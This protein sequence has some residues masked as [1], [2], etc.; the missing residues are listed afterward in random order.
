MAAPTVRQNEE[1]RP[2]EGPPEYF[3]VVLGLEH[4]LTRRLPAQGALAIGRGE[5]A[6]VRIVDALASRAH[7][8]LHLGEAMEIEDLGSAN[9]TRLRD[10]P[11]S[12]HQRVPLAPGDA[13]SIGTTLLVVQRQKP[14]FEPR[15]IWSHGHFES[16]LIEVCAEA[17]TAK[18]SFALVR[19]HARGA[20]V[21]EIV[22]S[23]LRPGDLLAAYAPDEYEVLLVDTNRETSNALE[24]EMLARLQRDGAAARAGLAFFPGDGSSPQALVSR[25]CERLR[26]AGPPAVSGGP[27][28]ENAAMRQLYSVAEK[29]ARGTI[30]VLIVGE[31]GA[32]KEILAQ[33]V[34]RLSPRSQRPFIAFNCAALSDSLLES[35]LF[36][37]EK[38][39]FTGATQAKA[40]LLEAAH[41]GTLF[42]DEIGEMSLG[43][44]AKVLRAIESKQVLRVGATKAR[45]VDVRFVAATNRD[46]EEEIA[47]K[48]FREDL[49]FRLNGMT[50]EIP[51]LRDRVDEI[52][53]LARLFLERVAQQMGQ[54]PPPLGRD[55]VAHLQ[56][57]AWPGNIRELRNVM[58]RALLLSSGAAI[59]PEHLPLEKMKRS[60]RVSVPPPSK[61]E[62]LPASAPS[63]PTG[64]VEPAAA[65]TLG[66]L[67]RQAILD[68][69]VRCAGNQSRAA[70]LLGIPR[71][72]FCK[73]LAEYNIPRP[74]D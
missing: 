57:Y 19:L 48:R 46:L 9:G 15:R 17:E 36:G 18:G 51:P 21:E 6:E 63:A 7:A 54:P 41:G 26:P 23:V 13:I 73:R 31:T 38:G 37:Y 27:V 33:T 68:A 50:L 43:L 20:R 60:A 47:A 69:L 42:L 22:T 32:G 3:L 58:E 66:E 39:A 10:R 11:L 1:Q 29:A 4:T 8:R 72:T 67:E 5:E 12:P 34:H 71:R 28:L 49:Y 14:A 40:G 53:A 2:T 30:N 64:V 45:D 74:R 44:Q 61:P 65:I 59:T 62:P 24:G 16:R 35:E 70:E 56:D 52:P 25:A 55:V